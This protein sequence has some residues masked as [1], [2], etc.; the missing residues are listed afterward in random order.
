MSIIEKAKSTLGES[1]VYFDTRVFYTNWYFLVSLS[2]NVENLVLLQIKKKITRPSV[3][4][5]F[6]VY[7]FR[8]STYDVFSLKLKYKIL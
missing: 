3:D 7:I 5:V 1:R 2:S 6:L 8:M 4:K